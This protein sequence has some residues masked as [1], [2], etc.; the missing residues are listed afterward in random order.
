MI[1][2]NLLSTL[3]VGDTVVV[4]TSG[5]LGARGVLRKVTKTD[6][7]YIYID[8]FKYRKDNGRSVGSDAWHWSSIEVPSEDDITRIKRE[9]RIQ[10]LAGILMETNWHGVPLE[11]LEKIVSLLTE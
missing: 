7:R 9:D 10:K 5:G 4:S 1:V 2:D 6:R 8:G 3:R 11:K